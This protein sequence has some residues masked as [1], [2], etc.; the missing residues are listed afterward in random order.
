MP[1]VEFP[2]EPQTRTNQDTVLAYIS[3]VRCASS[4][5]VLDLL[6]SQTSFG[7]RVIRV[8]IRR[9]LLRSSPL[10][11]R[12]GPTSKKVLQLASDERPF[13]LRGLQ[14]AD[15]WLQAREEGYEWMSGDP[16][17]KIYKHGKELLVI[18]PPDEEDRSARECAMKL[19]H[20]CLEAEIQEVSYADWDTNRALKVQRIISVRNATVPRAHA[21]ELRVWRSFRERGD[22][23][24]R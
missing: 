11:G 8:A 21:I 9:N 24:F 20:V 10:A 4:H 17:P 22:P 19:L 23:R 7:Y 14:L 6:G 16:F 15:V 2:P 13:T 18:P 3:E 1:I 5:Q 12:G